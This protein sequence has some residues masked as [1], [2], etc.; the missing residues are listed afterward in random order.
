MKSSNIC[1]LRFVA[2]LVVSV[3]LN[4]L[5][6]R[7]AE[8]AIRLD[9][10]LQ[11]LS[12]PVYITNAHDGSQR[13]FVVE[14]PGRIKVL[15]SGAT[16][17]SLF[18]DI[19]SKVLF[20][21]EQGLLG[22][23][24]H[25]Q[26]ATNSRFFVDYTRQTDGATVIAEYHASADP[27]ITA[28][29]ETVLLVIAQP[30]ANHNGGMIEF[31]GDGY[32]YI[33]M[34]DGGD[35]NDPQ[36]RAQNINELLG[37]ILRI[38]VDHPA[39]PNLYSSPASNPYAGATPGR[40]E[41]FAVGVRNPFRFSF[42]R[43]TGQLYVGDVG[44]SLFEEVDVVTA[45]GNYGWR[46]YEGTHCTGL[47]PAL[48]T[49]ANFVA[50]ILQYD[51]SGGRC[52]IIGGYVYRGSA[53]ALPAGTY[54]FGDFCTGEIF[55]LV[56]G[57]PNL[58]LDTSLSISSFGEDEA[59]ELY[60][61]GLAGTVHRISLA[62]SNATTTTLTSSGSPITV[63]SSV[64]FTATVSGTNPT[65]GVTFTEGGNA[66]A[67]CP[68]GTLSGTSA[69]A[70]CSTSS[71]AVG[72][73]SIVANYSGDAGNAASSSA[74]LS[75]VINAVPNA[76]T[77]LGTDLATQGNWKGIYG[78]DGYAILN[79]SSSY[80]AYAQ[81]TPAGQLSYVWNAQPGTDARALQR[82][83]SGRIAACWYSSGLVGG[84]FSV[85]VNL[86]DGATHRVALYL[87]DWDSTTRVNRVDVLD[88]ATQQVLSSQTLQSFNAGVY[89][90]WNLQGHVILRFTSTGG[91]NAVLSGLFFDAAAGTTTYTVSGTVTTS[92]TALSGVHF[93]APGNICTTSDAQGHY[94]CSVP[95]GWSGT[96][97]PSLSGYAFTPASR[98]YSS[99]AANQ[100]AQDYA[101][102]SVAATTTTLTSSG[103]PATVGSSVTFTA[104]VS[105]TNPTGSVSFIDRGN[106]I[107]GCNAIAFIGTGDS[108][109]ASCSTSNLAEGTHSIVANYSGDA[110]NA[111]S[112]SPALLQTINT[113]GQTAVTTHHNDISRTGA[114]LSETV[115]TTS[116]VS[117]ATF[118]KLFSHSVDGKIY[119]QILYV[120]NITVPGLGVH[121][122]VYVSTLNNSVYAFDADDATTTSPLWRVNLGP[123]VPLFVGSTES[124]GILSTPV[125]DVASQT[126]YVVAETSFNAHTVF[127]LHALELT[128]GAEKFGGPVEI[129]G[130]VQDTGAGSVDGRLDFAPE[131]HL[132]RP[133]LLLLNGNVYITF[134]SYNDLQPYHGWIFG[135]SATSLQQTGILCVSP[136]ADGAAIWQGGVAPAADAYGYIYLMTGNGLLDARD[137]GQNY[138]DLASS[139]GKHVGWPRDSSTTFSP[140]KSGGPQR[141]RSRPRLWR[142]AFDPRNVSARRR[143][144]GWQAVSS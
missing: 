105:G 80:P 99:V 114:Y 1:T 14:Q 55:S 143:W 74:P 11:G 79:D 53:A 117:L 78:N 30:Y 71:L 101:A 127:Q 119:A 27:N 83:A 28:A 98:N 66:I 22:L 125:I 4:A 60:V 77:F 107:G 47:D 111:I 106:L 50:P 32:L 113:V 109:T 48:C 13:M 51:H 86:T 93:A 120:P 134:G 97:T 128:T 12:S 92:S 44:Q 103:S 31:G 33:G 139:R 108:R 137:G 67:G 23:A 115:L 110:A 72:V 49:P 19:T 45:G 21:G 38:D 46:V 88:A 65:G 20:G 123:S 34:G 59:G 64:T 3:F 57:A 130:S 118:G 7:S 17:P 112:S 85:D 82:A 25:P 63:G 54:V 9:P 26:F 126:L 75:Q 133:G 136:T 29:S 56:S 94:S 39:D 96:V 35:A 138:G 100:S 124:I 68:A 40:D 10:V 16:T 102:T 6:M 2:L 24:F 122:V 129:R 87:L 84:S 18:L 69:T 61:V 116:N 42:D 41:I 144:Q 131:M 140:L 91:T 43:V 73:H 5:V 132:Q 15:A 76:A 90:L 95:Q 62:S 104:T 52:A 8:S 58:L 142:A 89:L 135:Y 121:N 81:V 36:S 141:I 70:A 37:K